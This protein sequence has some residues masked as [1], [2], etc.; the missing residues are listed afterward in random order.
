MTIPMP[1]R[2]AR[3]PRDKHGR[4][5]P[6]FVHRDDTGPDFR[7]VR[8]DGIRDAL[9]FGHCWVCGQKRGTFS[10]FV[11][12]PMCAI[13]RVSAEPPAHRDCATYSALACPFLATPEMRRRDHN[14]PDHQLPAGEMI[15]RNPGVTLVWITRKWRPQRV[16]T[17]VLF[18]L[19]DP[20][21]AL[22]Y[23]RGRTATRAEV[24]ESIQTGLPIL[25]QAAEQ[26]G[27]D[28]IAE[29]DKQRQAIEPLLPP[30]P[31]PAALS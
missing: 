18:S 19:G 24:L 7:V 17:G 12:G 20:E 22:W 30:D 21:E 23:A 6:W 28:A 29:L 14:L 31:A 5:I 10:A 11:V 4:P 25:L 2:I 15:L 3:L 9:R 27:A 8:E 13:N 16:G 1:P 26:D